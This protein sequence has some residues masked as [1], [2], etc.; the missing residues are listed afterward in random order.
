[1]SRQQEKID[2]NVLLMQIQAI[3]DQINRLQGFIAEL[4]TARESVVRS[5]DS[6]KALKRVGED[7]II[8]P[9]D[10]QMNSFTML[11]PVDADYVIVHLGLNVYARLPVND[12]VKI[13]EAKENRLS[14]SIS[15]AS[16]QLNELVKLHEQYQALL[17]SIAL[18]A[19]TQRQQQTR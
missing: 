9:L 16:K 11:K 13:L 7:N 1:M 6:V 3:R 14:R 2:P 8:L 10:P 19:Q 5:I 4:A 12:A 15:E 17:Q 18:S